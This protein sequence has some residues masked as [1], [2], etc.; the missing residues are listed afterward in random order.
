EAIFESSGT[1]GDQTSRHFIKDLAIY[2]QSFLQTFNLFYGAPKDWCI[3][4]LLPGYLE[5]GNSSLVKMVYGLIEE[6]G[7]A[8]SGFYL[9]NLDNLYQILV[10][11]ELKGQ[12]TLLIGVTFSLLDFA[13]NYAMNLKHTVIIET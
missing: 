1:T 8:R 10:S 9:D 2:R 5:R 11:N 13:E 6:S 12:P 3:V 7:N 4:G